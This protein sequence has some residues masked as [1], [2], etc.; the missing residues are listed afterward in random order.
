VQ[1]EQPPP[2]R[3]AKV[4]GPEARNFVPPTNNTKMPAG[5]IMI[6]GGPPPPP[7]TPTAQNTTSNPA[8]PQ[9][10]EPDPWAVPTKTKAKGTVVPVGGKVVLGPPKEEE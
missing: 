8:V 10:S 9:G 6:G 4:V 7:P 3:S 1:T 5:G 2:S